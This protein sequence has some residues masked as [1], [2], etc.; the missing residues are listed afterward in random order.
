MIELKTKFPKLQIYVLS[1]SPKR[2]ANIVLNHY[3]SGYIEE[4][5]F[6]GIF[7][8]EDVSTPKPN[9]EGILKILKGGSKVIKPGS[10]ILRPG[11]GGTM[12]WKELMISK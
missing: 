11:A 5:G 4:T 7:C 12:F 9:P 10:K 8:F 1:N 3:Y 2:Y 6:D